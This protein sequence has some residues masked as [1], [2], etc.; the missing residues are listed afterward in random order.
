[1]AEVII[2]KCLQKLLRN[3]VKF[4][5]VI[6]GQ[7]VASEGF[8]VVRQNMEEIVLQG[9]AGTLTFPYYDPAALAMELHIVATRE[10]PRPWS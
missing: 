10:P 6:C 3:V 5:H 2:H 8:R 1:M 4:F 7:D 9:A